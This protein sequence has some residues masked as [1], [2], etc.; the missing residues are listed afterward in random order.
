[1]HAKQVMDIAALLLGVLMAVA[2]NQSKAQ[3]SGL[4]EQKYVEAISRSNNVT[5]FALD[6]FGEK[7][8]LKDGGARFEWVDID[9]PGN[10]S[11]PVRLQRSRLI[12]DARTLSALGGFGLGGSF[13]VPYLSGVFP[14]AGWQVNGT[15]PNNRCSDPKAPPA[16]TANVFASDYWTGNSLHI[17]GD[18]EQLMLAQPSSVIPAVT[19]GQTYPWITKNFWRFR[20]L[21]TTKNGYPGEAFLALSPTGEK[22]YFDWV[23]T[24][25][26][27][28]FSKMYANYGARSSASMYVVRFLVS[29]I[30]DRHGN[31]VNFTYSGDLLDSIVAN[32]GRYIQVT[33]VSGGNIT[34][35]SSSVG[36]FTYAYSGGTTVTR[37]DGSTWVLSD[38]GLP[39]VDAPDFLPVYMQTPRCPLPDLSAGDY[40]MSIKAPNGAV[41]SYVFKVKRHFRHNIPKE[42][43]M[44]IGQDGL[45]Q[46]YQFLKTPNF[47]DSLTL[48][49]KSISGPGLP[50]M[51][52]T[53]EY[54]IGASPMA[55]EDVCST[56]GC[57]DSMITKIHGPNGQ[58]ETYKFGAKYQINENQ[59]LEVAKGKESGTAPN[60]V[61]T[62]YK[63][64]RYSYVQ[65]S[66]V[67]SYP[68][69]SLVGYELISASDHDAVAGLRPLKITEIVLDGKTFTN[70]VSA[71]DVFARP[72]QVVKTSTP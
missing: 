15:I 36:N 21:A 55:F 61:E 46:S 47:S 28:F 33:G 27:G 34:S 37:P 6:D 51:Q 25:S 56:T 8:N 69:P 66:E 4:A 38:T 48:M 60:V 1:M 45:F 30:E 71:F 52:W 26:R 11:L 20:C 50:A 58:L 41:A 9:I 18:G 68:F 5:P 10:S 53:Y 31:W 13:D 32:D 54:G 49:S 29:R 67:S 64:T 2:P 72:T 7:I 16:A 23:V 70:S 40:Q 44:Y 22:Y 43:M 59:L 57:G 19:D 3:A 63:R 65:A 42:C 17:P 62:I 12:E 39:W 14:S 24:K 35:V